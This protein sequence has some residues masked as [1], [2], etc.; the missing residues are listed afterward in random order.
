MTPRMSASSDST[1]EL[2]GIVGCTG[3]V[4]AAGRGGGC[5][6]GGSAAGGFGAGC[7]GA[8][9]GVAAGLGASVVCG[10]GTVALVTVQEWRLCPWAHPLVHAA[11]LV[12][13]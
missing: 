8:G 7:A 1:G 5:A 6:A 3:G 13:A 11:V 4:D 9:A 2:G 10:G 12:V